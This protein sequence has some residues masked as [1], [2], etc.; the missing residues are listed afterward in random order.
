MTK[1]IRLVILLVVMFNTSYGIAQ[2]INLECPFD[3]INLSTV[4]VA[5]KLPVPRK[6]TKNSFEHNGFLLTY[7]YEDGWVLFLEGGLTELW[8]DAYS[9]SEIEEKSDVKISR[10]KFDGNN[11]RRDYYKECRIYYDRVLPKDKLKYEKFLNSVKIL[12]PR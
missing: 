10:G 9:S 5:I 3:T 11:W 4:K 12:G 2:D 7:I 8:I 1:I 6:I